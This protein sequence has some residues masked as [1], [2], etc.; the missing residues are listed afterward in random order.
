MAIVED[1]VYN[2]RLNSFMRVAGQTDDSIRQ[3]QTGIAPRFAST[4]PTICR[5]VE[6][7]TI[8]FFSDRQTTK[9]YT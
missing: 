2:L 6:N 7:L 4:P 1:G 8:V 5:P 3:L 9:S